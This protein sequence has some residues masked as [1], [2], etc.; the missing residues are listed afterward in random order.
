MIELG[1]A[2]DD[3]MV[4]AFLR[5][6]IDLPKW[7]PDYFALLHALRL[8]R[9]YLIDAADLLDAYANCA[10][11]V[12]LGAVR[13]YGRGE[14]LFQ[15]F[16]PDTKWRRV[17]IEPSDFHRL[18]YINGDEDWRNLSGHTRLVQMALAIWTPIP[19]SLPTF[20]GRGERS[21]KDGARPS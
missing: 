13:G 5:A 16:P 19:A 14:Q 8:D 21:S 15:G 11:K 4:L 1:H 6:E 2:S 18:K 10:R 12:V 7:G 9:S 3:E 20:A 17:S